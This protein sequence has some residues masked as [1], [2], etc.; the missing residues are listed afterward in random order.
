MCGNVQE[1]GLTG[2]IPLIK[3]RLSGASILLFSILS[4]RGVTVKTAAVAGGLVAATSF[5]CRYGR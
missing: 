3:P 4:P 1:S 2:A 5:V